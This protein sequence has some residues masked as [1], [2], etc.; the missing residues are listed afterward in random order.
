MTYEG[1]HFPYFVE[2][3]GA[4]A[5]TEVW[6]KPADAPASSLKQVYRDPTLREYHQVTIDGLEPGRRYYFEAY[7][8]GVKAVPNYFSTSLIDP[9]TRTSVFETLTPPP[10]EFVQSV[11]ILNDTHVGLGEHLITD[12]SEIPYSYFILEDALA[13]IALLAPSALIVNGDVTSEARPHEL[14]VARR[15]LDAYGV[16][17]E[18]YFLTRG[19]H[20]RPHAAEEDPRADYESGTLLAEELIRPRTETTLFT[21]KDGTFYDNVGDFFDLPYQQ[22]WTTRKG[23]LRII[24]L[25][26]SDA[27]D[28][29][30]GTIYDEQLDA[31][32]AELSS[33][34]DAPTIVFSH[35]PLTRQQALTAFGSR[36][37]L[38]SKKAATQVEEIEAAAPGTFMHFG[39]HT[40]RGRRSK[41]HIA[42]EVD[43]VET[44]A[45]GEYPCVYSILNLYTGGYTLTS[46]R[47]D[48]E[49]V[50]GRM[51]AERWS[52]S[53]VMPDTLLYRTDHRNYSVSS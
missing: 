21:K 35:H 1:W 34:P 26:S 44:P 33:D 53:G 31:F 19:N 9:M 47:P 32:R 49:R 6:L 17:K 8:N 18:D 45:S 42:T 5:D 37:F 15:L 28:S 25:D 41:G 38:M 40:H 43:F 50:A 48:T 20:D 52:Q 14:R 12:P 29:A 3:E 30:G 39:G 7:S 46:H 51:L 16:E 4:F 22:M 23:D 11:A 10:G 36:P 24:G 2:Q 13:E 27:T